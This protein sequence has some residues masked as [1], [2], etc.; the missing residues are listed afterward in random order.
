MR[1]ATFAKWNK[2]NICMCFYNLWNC[3]VCKNDFEYTDEWYL[4]GIVWHPKI[5]SNIKHF[6]IFY[7]LF[8]ISVG[9]CDN[10]VCVYTH[11]FMH[12]TAHVQKTTSWAGSLFLP[13]KFWGLISI[14]E[15]WQ[16]WALWPAQPSHWLNSILFFYLHMDIRKYIEACICL[17]YFSV[18]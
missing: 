15:A 11:E 12:A 16:H 13:Q 5:Q 2:I 8:C 9:L 18:F 3:F 6:F 14:C 17:L 4:P 10:V 7:Y 1:Y